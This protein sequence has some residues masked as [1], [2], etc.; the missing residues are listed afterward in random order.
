MKFSVFKGF[1]LALKCLFFPEIMAK[2]INSCVC[3]CVCFNILTSIK[4]W[5]LYVGPLNVFHNFMD[6]WNPEI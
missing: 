5:Q 6:P 1:L 2:I 3:L 4:S